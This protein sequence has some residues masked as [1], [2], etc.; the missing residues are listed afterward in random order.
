MANKKFSEFT[1]KTDPTD[2]DFLVGYDGTDNVRIDPANIGGGSDFTYVYTSAFI[3]SSNNPFNF[4]RM[5]FK[6]STSAG[7]TGNAT[8]QQA[9]HC[10]YDGYVSFMQ[11]KNFPW[12]TPSSTQ[13]QLDIA[14]DIGT[15]TA[16]N[17]TSI[18]NSGVISHSA[19]SRFEITDTLSPT[20]ATFSAGDTLFIRYKTNG[21]LRNMVFNAV[22]VFQP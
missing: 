9:I 16:Q 5:P 2:V 11:L 15:T 4:Y 19:V 8:I 17:L 3:A 13:T 1:L 14:K 21:I 20:D 22:F 7:D 10:P 12:F 6:A 18:Y